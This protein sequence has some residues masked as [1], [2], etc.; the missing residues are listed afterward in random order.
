MLGLPN[1]KPSSQE[2]C[3]SLTLLGKRASLGALLVKNLP[4]NAGDARHMG[5]TPGLESS[6]GEGND[7]TP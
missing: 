7:N 1:H 2:D 5:S 6:P 4:A 3:K